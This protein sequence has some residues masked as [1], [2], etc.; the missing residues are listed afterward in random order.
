MKKGTSMSYTAL[1]RKFRPAS[2]DEVK[3]QDHIVRTLKNQIESGRVG[4]AYL[5]C[6]TR[7]T[8][9]TSV[10]KILARAVNCEHPING[11]PCGSCPMCQEISA[12]ASMNVI[13]IDAAS[14]NGVDNIRQVIEE[15]A[16]PPTKGYYKV[17]IIDEVHMLSIGAFNAL[18]KTLEEPPSYVMFILATT[19]AHKVPVTIMSRCQRY[20]FKRITRTEIAGHLKNLAD[21]E[22]L[23][24]EDR[25]FDYIAK[26]ADGSMRDALSLL[27]QCIAFNFGNKLTYDKILE[28]LG[29][30]D[31]HVMYSLLEA[32]YKSDA[33][34]TMQIIEDIVLYGK[35]LS[36]FILDFTWYLRN[37]MLI[38]ISEDMEE[39]LDAS[40]E[41]LADMKKQAETVSTEFLMRCINRLSEL[42]AVLKTTT[43]KR[44][45]TEVCF[46]RLCKPEMEADVD[47]LADR[48]RLLEA[49][50][51]GQTIT[52]PH[53]PD[54]YAYNDSEATA[55]VFENP[56]PESVAHKEPEAPVEVKAPVRRQEPVINMTEPLKTEAEAI[57]PVQNSDLIKLWPKVLACFKGM[58]KTMLEDARA[59]TDAEGALLLV[60]PKTADFSYDYV[61]SFGVLDR[62]SDT[63][64]KRFGMNISCRA[65][66]SN[67]SIKTDNNIQKL[68]QLVNVPVEEEF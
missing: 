57:K 19:E 22:G 23:Q 59:T 25:A 33:V 55:P 41:S 24:Y 65:I 68:R 4:H 27:D 10:A 40:S 66:I 26:Q 16:Y 29:T 51:E 48:I 3:G 60:Y 30:V 18:L 21:A 67:E 8:G 43:Q 13:E 31:T 9:K 39:V 54:T 36:Q 47:G 28:V 37:L 38:G 46:I 5:F 7:G 2:F 52:L 32:V 34:K 53:K 63:F 64:K 45:M 58:D 6:G 35:E 11:A 15:V 14:N 44:V 49:R 62:I 17:Y 42:T 61:Q 12:G 50:L 20:D 1:Y 56:K